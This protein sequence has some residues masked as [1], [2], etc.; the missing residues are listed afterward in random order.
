[1]PGTLEK[2]PDLT[3]DIVGCPARGVRGGVDV[4]H[5]RDKD[6]GGGVSG[7]H[8]QAWALLVATIFSKTW[9]HPTACR[10][11]CWRRNKSSNEQGE[12]Q[13]HQLADRLHKGFL[14]PQLPTK[15]SLL[16]WPC[17]PRMTPG[18][19]AN[20]RDQFFLPGGLHKPLGLASPTGRKQKPKKNYSLWKKLK[21]QKDKV[22]YR[23]CPRQRNRETPEQ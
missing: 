19:P 21:S 2:G 13:P 4:A 14:T 7:E 22:V 5:C 10:L 9:P 6:T 15:H 3:A 12:T 11:Q 16:I 8:P 20:G 17:P 1:M 23:I 18:P